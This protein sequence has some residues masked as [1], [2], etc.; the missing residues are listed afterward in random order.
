MDD[1]EIQDGVDSEE[2]EHGNEYIIDNDNIMGINSPNTGNT[3]QNTQGTY[4]T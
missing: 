1:D 2:D 4:I 3:G